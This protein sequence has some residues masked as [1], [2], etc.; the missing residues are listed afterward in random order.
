MKPQEAIMRTSPLSS[1][2]QCSVADEFVWD[3]LDEELQLVLGR[4]FSVIELPDNGGSTDYQR[5]FDDGYD[6]AQEESYINS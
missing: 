5:G 6:Q 4:V 3:E 2:A 1:A